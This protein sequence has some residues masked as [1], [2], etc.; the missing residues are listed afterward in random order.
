MSQAEGPCSLRAGQLQEVR[1]WRRICG[2]GSGQDHR[3]RRPSAACQR[4]CLMPQ[5]SAAADNTVSAEPQLHTAGA[6]LTVQAVLI[7]PHATLLAALGSLA[8][9]R[10]HQRPL[11]DHI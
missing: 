3:E 4:P 9:Q 11:A 2:A 6:M 10:W 5:L 7:L 1:R 8:S